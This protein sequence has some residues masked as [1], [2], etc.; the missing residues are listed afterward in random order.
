M[1]LAAPSSNAQDLAPGRFA[2]IARGPVGRLVVIAASA[3]LLRQ[4]SAQWLIVCLAAATLTLFK[5]RR[6][7]VVTAI[8]SLA[9]L[10]ST[11]DGFAPSPA[12]RFAQL[13]D[14]SSRSYVVA[15]YGSAVLALAFCAAFLALV[16]SGRP[17]GV[18]R[19]PL[20]SLLALFA[21]LLLACEYAPAPAGARL[22]LWALAS[23]LSGYI[24]F[25][26]LIA[27][28]QR[29]AAQQ[30]PFW[31]QMIALHP[32]WGS[33]GTPYTPAPRKLDRLAAPDAETLFLRQTRA[34]RLLI[35][36]SILLLVNLAFQK[37]VHGLLG[38]PTIHN[39]I[40][41]ALVLSW[42]MRWLTLIADFFEVILRL[43]I[44]GHGIVAGARMLG[45]D[46]PR[47]TY[48]PLE[49][50]NLIEFWGRYYYYFKE[51][52][53][54]LFYFPTFLTC[55]RAH[56][57]LRIAFATFTAAG[58]GNLL[59]HF[60]RELDA[61]IELGL[62]KSILG[63]QTYALYCVLLSAGIIASQLRARGRA[64][65]A[66]TLSGRIRGF[67][68]VMLFFCLLQVF[69]DTSRTVPLSSH[70]AFFLSLFQP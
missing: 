46:L 7:A 17:A 69:D 68:G 62:V 31:R 30:V 51:L 33:T 25:L 48:R 66:P 10:I 58:V 64:P 59:F 61:V 5:G 8:A 45:F 14:L 12:F 39:A 63:L 44:F 28:E 27:G 53:L 6:A 35:W 55:F 65:V 49:A 37:V 56:P 9:G 18:A 19:R 67:G 54:N 21:V 32:A 38:V 43:A 20:L 40:A 50:R 60:L 29:N 15:Q 26:A 42:P 41:G 70:V 23:Q 16:R 57:R 34:F 2:E 4:V 52:L 11:P 1:T 22:W 24:F 13:A 3:P 36:A 47:N